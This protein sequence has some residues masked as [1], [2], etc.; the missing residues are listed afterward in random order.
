MTHLGISRLCS[1]II[2][3]VVVLGAV[4]LSLA[5]TTAPLITGKSRTERV[6]FTAPSGVVQIKLEV[7]SETG[8]PFFEI[9]R[10]GNILDWELKS[11]AGERL[12]QGTFVC[13]VTV[14]T[15]SGKSNSRMGNIV[16]T[17]GKATLKPKATL[18]DGQQLIVGSIEDGALLIVLPDD[19]IPSATVVGHDGIN[20][21]IT[22]TTGDLTFRTGDVY[23]GTEKEQ[24][25]ITTDGKIGVGTEDPQA[26]LDVVGSFR[27]SDGVR[28]SD[29]T[30]IIASNGRLRVRS[31]DGSEAPTA[32]GT[33][34]LN[35]LAKWA[36]TGGA[37]TLIDAGGS[38]SGG[39]TFFG[40]NN[41]NQVAPLFGGASAFHVFEI[42]ATGS[43]SP[44]TLAGG[45][46]VMEF[47]RDL[48]AGVGNPAAAV[49]FGMA[50]PGLAA[51]NDMVFSTYSIGPGWNERMRIATGGNVGIGT[52]TPT[53]RFSVLDNINT[54][55]RV[56]NTTGGG[57]VASFG[58]NGAF[59]IDSPG[60]AG[61]RFVVTEAGFTGLGTSTPT[62]R[63]EVLGN[64]KLNGGGTGIRFADGSFLT[65]ATAGGSPSGTV[66]ISAINDPATTGTINPNRLSPLVVRMQP[67]S[68]QISASTNGLG[69]D[70]L[71]DLRGTYT[72][73]SVGSSDFK[74]T[75][76]GTLIMTG[77]VRDV[78]NTTGCSALLPTSG[79]GTKFIWHPCRGSLRFGRVPTAQTN[80]DD[81]NMD[82]FT[83]AGGNQVTASGY[84]AFAFGDQVTASSTVGVGFGSGVTVS[85]TAGFSAGASN[86]CSGFACTAIGYTVTAGGQGSVALGYRTTANNDY[87]VAIGYRASNNTHTGSMV[88]GDE[89]TTT[90]VNNQA[91][92]E[93]R[94]RYNG[95]FRL[96]VSTAANGNTPGAGGNIGCD[97][98]VAVPSWT[99]A[100][101]RDV[102][103][104]FK[105]V[106]GEEVL[107]KLRGMPFMTFNYINDKSLTRN[108]GPVA[109]DFYKAFKLGDSDKSINVQNMASV[110]LAGV[111][112]LEARTA[113]LQKENDELRSTLIALEARLKKL[114]NKVTPRTKR[115]AKRR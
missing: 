64:I 99:C 23:G 5:Q 82:D 113:T 41:S 62:E 79:A 10:N 46:G 40:L 26:T 48:G 60:F 107:S 2:G 38:E 89:S 73:P 106:K 42:G 88:M 55:I 104:N 22:S 97:L 77:F 100:S 105:M 108:F 68:Q 24:M 9:A 25:R 35:R 31:A 72:T 65:S 92:N 112:A 83:F 19:D 13:K 109:E 69:T 20:G 50:R 30:S 91:D 90:D 21:Q 16:I 43:K 54:G 33:G 76:Q 34:T 36:E 52:S 39:L 3:T 58:S 84:G 49:G 53:S 17:N 66:V 98:T 95:G 80:W 102:K 29:G 115:S 8:A 93:F 86:I 44:L 45:S 70:S 110:S 87:S 11:S 96:R 37:G 78:G 28:F 57:T 51:T 7:I 18:T 4:G 15:V 75:N 103:E 14:Q 81:A 101:S 114:E 56:Q 6:R 12:T 94:A 32:A 1:A 74:F 27:V 85:G 59:Q 61:G 63:L 111:Q 71:I 47:W 67:T